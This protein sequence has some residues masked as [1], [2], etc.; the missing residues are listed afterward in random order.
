MTNLKES[1]IE[2]IGEIPK[3]WEVKPLYAVGHERRQR[4]LQGSE[5][6]L[7]SLSYGEI[8]EKHIDSN[9]GLLPESFD[10]YQVIEPND[11]VFRFTDLQNDKRSLRSARSNY[12]GIIT[13]AY[14]SF[15]P[16]KCDSRYLAHLFRSYDLTK[17]FYA[18]GSGLRQSLKW[19]D[20]RRMP[21]VVPPLGEQKAIADFLELELANI[22]SLI[23]KQQQLVTKLGL[24]RQAVITNAVT[25]GLS[26]D[27]ELRH[28]GNTWLGLIPLHWELKP[29]KYLVDLNSKTLPDSTPSDFEFNYIEISDVT[30]TS[31]VE[32]WNKQRFG[33]APS[34]ARRVVE[35][36]DV[37]V[38]T[39]RTYLRAVGKVP[40]PEDSLHFVASTG[41][42]ALSPRQVS[43]DFLNYALTAEHFVSRVEADSTGI[44]YPAINASDLVSIQIPTPPLDEQKSIAQYLDFE[45][46]KIDGVVSA[47]MRTIGLLRERKNA[48]ITAAVSG[49]IEITGE[50]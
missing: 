26:A 4:N 46:G 14:M 48:V 33:E 47:S 44:S 39:V 12:S 11:L 3:A 30:N 37:L 7:L 2:W 13:S 40:M 6:N 50:N 17:V 8:V 49:E 25:R 45:V 10:S 9:D 41:F 24:R 31:G 36:G 29:L 42:A 28:T 22:D 15:R 19:S 18:M 5:A 20:V 34:R 21:I 32:T 27:V 23:E 35:S 1:G 16:S 38:S 43:S